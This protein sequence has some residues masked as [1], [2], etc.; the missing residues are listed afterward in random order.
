M[1][2]GSNNAGWL[3]GALWACADTSGAVRTRSTTVGKCELAAQESRNQPYEP[4]GAFSQMQPRT[5]RRG[6]ISAPHKAFEQD[7]V[8]VPRQLSSDMGFGS[9]AGNQLQ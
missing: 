6:K 7:R 2:D 9:Q 1:S 4:L 3:S 5:Q 8:E